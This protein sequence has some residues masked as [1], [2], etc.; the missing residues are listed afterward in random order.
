MTQSNMLTPAQIAEHV[1]NAFPSY[2]DG[3]ALGKH[4]RVLE[5]IIAEWYDRCGTVTRERDAALALA[6]Q[7]AGVE[8]AARAMIE[9]Y[10]ACEECQDQGSCADAY[11]LWMAVKD[12]LAA[13]H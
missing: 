13:P 9:H 1:E 11:D 5:A 10:D 12:A 7:R 6:E 8:T 3:N 2:S 4:I